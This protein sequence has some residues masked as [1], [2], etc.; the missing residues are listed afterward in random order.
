M[1][2]SAQE[3]HDAERNRRLLRRWL[4]RRRM[5]LTA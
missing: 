4:L 3:A 2:P 1:N 5:L